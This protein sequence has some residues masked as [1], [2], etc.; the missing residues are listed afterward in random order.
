MMKMVFERDYTKEKHDDLKQCLEIEVALLTKGFE[1]FVNLPNLHINFYLCLHTHTYATLRNTQVGIKETVHKI[2]KSMV[3]KTNRKVIE[4]DLL[5][6]YSTIFA[7]RHF[8]DG[9]ADKRF[10]RSYEGFSALKK[11]TCKKLFNNWFVTEDKLFDENDYND[12]TTTVQLSMGNFYNIRLKKRISLN[13]IKDFVKFFPSDD[14]FMTE[15]SI[16]YNELG[17]HAALIN[18]SIIWYEMAS[19]VT[20]DT[21]GNKENICLKLGDVVTIQDKEYSESFA[22]IQLNFSSQIK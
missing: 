18:S 4:K 3:L 10:S 6:C 19:Y 12:E 14:H 21:F 15:L 20:E 2:F 11:S 7:I 8:T 17:L 5:K 9:G 13:N 22:M 1:E 16:S